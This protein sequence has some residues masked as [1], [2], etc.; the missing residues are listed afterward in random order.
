MGQCVSQK[1]E[2]RRHDKFHAKIVADKTPIA[3][4]TE[5]DEIRDLC[6]R[7]ERLLVA[8]EKLKALEN[9]ADSYFNEFITSDETMRRLRW[10]TER[11]DEFAELLKS[12]ESTGDGH[13]KSEVLP[14]GKQL[15]TRL[16]PDGSVIIRLQGKLDIPLP[17]VAALINE[18]DLQPGFIPWLRKAEKLH[19]VTGCGDFSQALCRLHYELPPPLSPRECDLFCFG[20][21]AMYNEPFNGFVLVCVSPPEH[22]TDWWG[23][24][25]PALHDSAVQLDMRTLSFVLRPCQ[26]GS[27]VTLVMNAD[28]RL[29]LP[30]RFLNWMS[31]KTMRSAFEGMDRLS[32]RFALT[33][34]PARVASD[35][36][37]YKIFV[38]DTI[39]ARF[40]ADLSPTESF[41]SCLE[42]SLLCVYDAFVV[43]DEGV[44]E[45]CT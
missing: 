4:A 40:I 23:Y 36:E 16:Q 20:C 26:H 28:F 6:N 42:R 13:W 1:R 37:F 17:H 29:K 25:L 30:H 35:R 34:Y 12:T 27:E 45:T 11:I 19:K 2:P 7:K 5:V 18:V 43:S 32:K 41:V 22:S 15:W 14:D 21:D 39:L 3:W 9:K 8:R 38:E 24:P 31:L 10:K 33:P 44:E